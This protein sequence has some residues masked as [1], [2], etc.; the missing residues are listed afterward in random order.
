[1][2]QDLDRSLESLPE[3]Y[4]VERT[5]GRG[6]FGVVVEAFDQEL[7]RS[8][9]IKVQVGTALPPEERARF[10]RE[11]RAMA[12]VSHPHLVEVLDVGTTSTGQLFLVLPRMDGGTLADRIA[13]GASDPKEVLAWAEQGALALEALAN[14]GWVHR[15]V[16]PENLFLTGEGALCLGDFG[17]ARSREGSSLT[18][19]GTLLGTPKYMPLE[20]FEGD[21]PEIEFD[22]YGLAWSLLEAA[23]GERSQIEGGPKE[24]YDLLASAPEARAYLPRLSLDPA[25]NVLL[26]VARPRVT[27]PRISI[28]SFLARLRGNEEVD[29]A[30]STKVLTPPG[31]EKSPE[32]R[33]EQTHARP[34]PKLIPKPAPSPQPSGGLRGVESKKFSIPGFALGLSFF[35]LLGFGL[36]SRP[37]KAPEKEKPLWIPEPAVRTPPSLWKE[38]SPPDWESLSEELRYPLQDLAGALKAIQDFLPPRELRGEIQ[39]RMDLLKRTCERLGRDPLQPDIV[40]TEVLA[41]QD[42]ITLGKLGAKEALEK[43]SDS[44]LDDWIDLLFLQSE[45]VFDREEFIFASRGV[46]DR[47]F[48]GLEGQ[49]TEVR[50][51]WNRVE[52][53]LRELESA[54]KV[55][56]ESP[57]FRDFLAV[58]EGM[59]RLHNL[60]FFEYLMNTRSLGSS[61][62]VQG[63]FHEILGNEMRRVSRHCGNFLVGIQCQNV[64][65]R[66]ETMRKRLEVLRRENPNG[67]EAFA[68]LSTFSYVLLDPGRGKNVR[69][70]P[71]CQEQIAQDLVGWPYSPPELSSQAATVLVRDLHALLRGQVLSKD[72]RVSTQRFRKEVHNQDLRLRARLD[73]LLPVPVSLKP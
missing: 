18:R 41:L 44:A 39:G 32:T 57:G 12:E 21:P 53:R 61:A 4:R 62:R 27:G 26:Q 45:V 55:L 2:G 5:L 8:V 51:H 66:V 23:Q 67:S 65:E 3:R 69:C 48:E 6:G 47:G 54:W 25:W 50:S 16:K 28:S 63:K 19:S 31:R 42:L 9:A 58:S 20:L 22:L 49:K 70:D 13:Q 36:G 60:G 17:L 30:R 37:T 46:I 40:E 7:A 56:P 71:I 72:F 1:M 33:S 68:I 29:R 11:G 14:Q 52:K 59:Q 10:L 15:D 64:A 35:L 38:G 34:T 43:F 73:S 24:V